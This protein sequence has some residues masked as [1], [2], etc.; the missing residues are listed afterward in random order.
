[1]ITAGEMLII[2][3]DVTYDFPEGFGSDLAN[4][5]SSSD[6]KV[7]ASFIKEAV[8][9]LSDNIYDTIKKN[10][11]SS[12]LE[13]PKVKK[14]ILN[15]V[16]NLDPRILYQECREAARKYGWKLGVIFA[17]KNV[18]TT[19]V[20]PPVLL[21]FG[22]HGAAAFAAIFPSNVIFVPLLIKYFKTHG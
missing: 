22:L 3:E 1:M 13:Y 10:F 16:M 5:I 18:V 4:A 2:L 12:S 17:V 20:I 15:A 21:A 6:P 11:P 19:F 9:S 7:I 8:V 14:M